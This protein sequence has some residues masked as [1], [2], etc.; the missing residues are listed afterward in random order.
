MIMFIL[1]SG[2]VIWIQRTATEGAESLWGTRSQPTTY[3][4][5][6]PRLW[7]LLHPVGSS[8]WLFPSPLLT[9]LSIFCCHLVPTD[10]KTPWASLLGNKLSAGKCLQ[11]KKHTPEK[12][13]KTTHHTEGCW[14]WC[15]AQEI[16]W[17]GTKPVVLKLHCAWESP[18][19]VC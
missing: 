19:R 7:C 8:P 9:S 17:Q 16:S 6:C 5:F 1:F 12:K 13:N 3:A 14:C 11:I 18:W 10:A 4:S 15:K 2:W